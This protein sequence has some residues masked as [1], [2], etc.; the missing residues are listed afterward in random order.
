MA[1]EGERIIL[2]TISRRRLFTES[3]LGLAAAGYLAKADPLGL[4]IGCQTYPVRE[5]LGKDFDG[6]LRELSGIGYKTIEMCSPPSY[7]DGYA[8]LIG[9]KASELRKHIQDAGLGCDSCHYGFQELKDSLDDRIAFG[10]ELG[11]KQMVLSSFGLRN[12][13]LADYARAAGDAN[14]IAEKVHAAGLD[15]GYH[16]HDMEFKTMDGVLVYDKLMQEFDPKL[17]KMQFQVSVISLGY[18]A[19]D[20]M[21]KYPGRFISMHLQDWSSETKKTVPIG[22]GVV[23]WKQTFAAA[24]T[25]G[26][27]NYFVEMDLADMKASFPY[28]HNLKV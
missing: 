28:L 13:G 16:N 24:K 4:P 19:S 25:G 21:T 26:V 3:A 20:Y 14:K 11:L 27:K 15:F 17:V 6:T 18:K 2:R 23:D 10:K 9:M 1:G 22:E 7:K 12:P 8:P 5:S